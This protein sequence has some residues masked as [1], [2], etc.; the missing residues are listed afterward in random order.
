MPKH[1][2]EAVFTDISDTLAE[3]GAWPLL[4]RA[5]AH[6]WRDFGWTLNERFYSGSTL[7]RL[8]D[9]LRPALG[10]KWFPPKNC[11]PIATSGR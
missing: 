6:I 11:L 2:P 10:R 4:L 5:S 3:L 1:K 9:T 8:M 7:W